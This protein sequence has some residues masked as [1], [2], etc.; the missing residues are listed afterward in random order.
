MNDA[1]HA[2]ADHP[3]LLEAERLLEE[4][5]AIPELAR[6]WRSSEQRFIAGGQYGGMKDDDAKAAQGSEAQN[7]Q[8]KPIV[9][10]QALANRALKEIL[11]AKDW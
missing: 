8:L 4:G 2:G 7:R 6:R 9:T 10:D 1:G 5:K 11:P 3:Q